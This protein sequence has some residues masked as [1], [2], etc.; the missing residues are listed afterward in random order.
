MQWRR[1]AR[2]RRVSLRIDP[3]AGMVVVTLPP[4]ASRRAGMSLLMTH[5][6]WVTDR[7]ARL[8][9]MIRFGDG[10]AIPIDGKPCRIRHVPQARGGAWFA[11]GELH[12]TGALEFLGR[13]VTDFLR[14]EARRR[15]TSDGGNQG[16]DGVVAGAASD[17]EG[18]KLALGKLRAGRLDRAVLAA[19]HGAGVRAGLRGGARGRTSAPHEPWAAVLGCG[20]VPDAAHR[21]GDD[22]A[23]HEGARL[24]RTGG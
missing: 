16:G 15:F 3:G 22:L 20:G 23:A 17:G 6:D 24:Q 7:L 5:A 21:G 14:A 12:V 1:S 11:D 4:R 13:R 18:H 2:A 19:D 8:P 10:E 9:R